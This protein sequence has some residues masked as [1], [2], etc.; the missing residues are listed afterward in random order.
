MYVARCEGV[1]IHETLGVA[2]T[3]HQAESWCRIAAKLEVKA[4]NATATYRV[5]RP[6]HSYVVVPFVV[7]THYADEPQKMVIV[8]GTVF[9]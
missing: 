6:Y 7:G 3:R 8:K 5:R 1:Y 2:T 4:E 9:E